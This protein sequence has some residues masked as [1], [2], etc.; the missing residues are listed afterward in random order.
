L[1]DEL[2]FCASAGIPHSQFL[3][4][5]VE[6]QAK[7]LGWRHW[8]SQVCTSCGKHRSDWAEP[9]GSEP[10]I[11][12][13]ELIDIYCGPCELLADSRESQQRRP[14]YHEGFRQ[15]PTEGGDEDGGDNE[16]DD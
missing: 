3:R 8:S 13:V 16:E 7:A 12:P 10:L 15:V 11:L 5:S 14:G 6:D 4:W 2:A 9:D 1:R